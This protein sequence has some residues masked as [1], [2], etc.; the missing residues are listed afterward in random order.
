MKSFIEFIF[1]WVVV[2]FSAVGATTQQTTNSIITTVRASNLA[3]MSFINCALH[4]QSL[5]GVAKRMK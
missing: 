4:P 3:S 1:F 5:G 2:S